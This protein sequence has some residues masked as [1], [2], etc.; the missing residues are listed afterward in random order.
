MAEDLLWL[1]RSLL[2]VDAGRTLRLN[3]LRPRRKH[4]DAGR[5]TNANSAALHR[6]MVP[7]RSLR[8]AAG[9]SRLGTHR[10]AL[11]IR[12][13]ASLLGGIWQVSEDT[14]IG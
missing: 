11:R 1:A 2:T 10:S 5:L 14:E 8:L 13:A 7:L 12:P 9:A 4:S 6:Q 3:G